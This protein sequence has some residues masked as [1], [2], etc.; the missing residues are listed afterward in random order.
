MEPVKREGQEG[1]QLL[2]KKESIIGSSHPIFILISSWSQSSAQKDQRPGGLWYSTESKLNSLLSTFAIN[3]APP[4]SPHP[5]HRLA[6]TRAESADGYCF[7]DVHTSHPSTQAAQLIWKTAHLAGII[8]TVQQCSVKHSGV[9]SNF[10]TPHTGI[11]A[12]SR[13]KTVTESRQLWDLPHNSNTSSC[14]KLAYGNY[15][16]KCK[17]L[18]KKS[19]L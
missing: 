7:P 8:L 16:D 1:G 6:E 18:S 13:E 11:K 10:T 3:C 5:M 2:E 12:S 14:L 4:S 17:L 15:P 9:Q 19:I